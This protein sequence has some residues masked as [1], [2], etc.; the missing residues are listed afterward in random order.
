MFEK[1]LG[2]NCSWF[3]VDPDVNGERNRVAFESIRCKE[4]RV[5]LLGD[6]MNIGVEGAR[7]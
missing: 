6:A 7:F 3:I 2:L 1:T 4:E 5:D